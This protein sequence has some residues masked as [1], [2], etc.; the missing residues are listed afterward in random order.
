MATPLLENGTEY[1]V[2]KISDDLW[3]HVTAG[4]CWF[5][6]TEEGCTS[7]YEFK[8]AI[9]LQFNRDVSVSNFPQA[10][11]K[12]FIFATEGTEH[13]MPLQLTRGAV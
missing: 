11:Y 3:E 12:P 1:A 9:S 10:P 13:G 2:L 7:Q 8:F 4:G 5:Y 6:K